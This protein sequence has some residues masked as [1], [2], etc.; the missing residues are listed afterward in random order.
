MT[1]R[2]RLERSSGLMGVNLKAREVEKVL[3]LLKSSYA[4]VDSACDC[5]ERLTAC[6]CC[7]VRLDIADFDK[8]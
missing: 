2:K 4:L 5:K 8:E 6:A 1:L 7:T 3:A